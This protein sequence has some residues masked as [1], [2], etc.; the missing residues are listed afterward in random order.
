M[1]RLRA[2]I[3]LSATG[4][5]VGV[6][7]AAMAVI[8]AP[9]L[10]V[11]AGS[12]WSAPFVRL[13]G[14][15]TLAN[16]AAFLGAPG[17]RELL[18]TTF[19]MTAGAALLAMVTGGALAWIVTRTDVPLRSYVRWLPVAS[20]LLS[21][22]LRDISWIGL[23][24]GH[25]GLVNLAIMRLVGR[26]QPVFE[27]FSLTGVITTMGLMLAPIPYLILL[28]PLASI[29]RGL[30]E[31]SRA[32]G[33]GAL[34]TLTHVTLPLL[35]PALLSGLTLTAI[36]VA[37]AFETPVIIGLPAN[38]H[39]FV[40]S[41][42]DTMSTRPNYSLASAESMVYLVLIGLLLLWYRRSTAVEARFA[43]I[44]GRGYAPGVSRTGPWRFVLFAIVVV[45]FL[46]T[47]AELLGAAV[48]LSLVPYFTVTSSTLPPMSADNYRDALAYPGTIASIR[49]SLV[50]SAE[51]ALVTIGLAI[52]V[53]L[54]GLKTR[55]RFR[56][57]A[58]LVGTLPIAFPP[59]VFS[60]ALLITFL[61]VP[62]MS[63][64]YNT[65]ALLLLSMVVVFLP[66]ALRVVSSAVIG[67]DDQLIEAS[68]SSGAGTLRTLRSIVL[69]LLA[70][71]ITSAVVVVFVM[72]F[73]ELGAVALVVPPDM[74]LLPVQIFGLWEGGLYGAVNA[75]NVVSFALVAAVLL[76]AGGASLLYRR[77]ARMLRSRGTEEA[78][79]ATGP[80]PLPGAPSP[81]P[82]SSGG[83]VVPG[84]G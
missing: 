79:S 22:L 10:V 38:V 71:A 65:V 21:G 57:L 83:G 56:R 17:T 4:V 82:S 46:V 35:R 72:S 7:V 78:L 41:I 15:L 25:V 8:V 9:I 27:I 13:A 52:V 70:T 47:F 66:Y 18:V 53:A 81:R 26:D 6:T 11:V 29:D 58:D 23:Y 33:A 20:L 49:D 1:E 50:V 2:R 36:I 3:R 84:S 5:G 64:L 54:V 61:S 43:T 12:L 45:Y 60:V 42:Y 74:P 40:S 63:G 32:S 34:R 59:L 69:P 55:V 48:Y 44:A 30:D 67:I 76:L 62:G 39:T 51:V 16:Y 19:A 28:G 14:H 73:R 80:L 77:G 37:H 68:A 75:M 31:A 24:S